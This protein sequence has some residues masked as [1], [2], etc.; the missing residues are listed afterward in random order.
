MGWENRP[1]C[2]ECGGMWELYEATN[3]KRCKCD[4]RTKDADLSGVRSNDLLD[5][6]I[7]KIDEWD[8]WTRTYKTGQIVQYRGVLHKV[9][10]AGD[11]GLRL[12]CKVKVV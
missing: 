6:Y 4:S 9:I 11:Q 7:P 10:D 12:S 1:D 5:D 3:R 2:E 8:C